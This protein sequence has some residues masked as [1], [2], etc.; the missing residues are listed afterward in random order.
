MKRKPFRI[1]LRHDW[2]DQIAS[3]TMIRDLLTSSYFCSD[4]SLVPSRPDN[5]ASTRD[6]VGQLAERLVGLGAGE[7][8][9]YQN[10]F[11]RF[12]I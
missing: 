7:K 9:L 5:L 4:I 3:R 2:A 1:V 12:Y 8:N 6:L 10:L 11:S